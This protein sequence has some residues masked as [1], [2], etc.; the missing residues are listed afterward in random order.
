MTTTAEG[1]AEEI[2]RINLGEDN[3]GFF[4]VIEKHT[5]QK[6]F[7]ESTTKYIKLMR[8]EENT[9]DVVERFANFTQ[10]NSY[11]HGYCRVLSSLK[12]E[13]GLDLHAKNAGEDQAPFVRFYLA[14]SKF[15]NQTVGNVEPEKIT[16]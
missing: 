15:L 4:N 1:R 7:L 16:S 2:D 6:F 10:L 8:M 13:F 9:P 14:C 5:G 11:L 3:S 12:Y